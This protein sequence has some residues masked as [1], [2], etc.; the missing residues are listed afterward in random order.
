M[1]GVIVPQNT[2]PKVLA[3]DSA[4]L[5]L[6]GVR[7]YG[8]VKKT[9]LQTQSTPFLLWHRKHGPRCCA[10]CGLQV[11]RI[12]EKSPVLPNLYGS[13]TANGLDVWGTAMAAYL[14][15]NQF[16][17]NFENSFEKDKALHN[18]VFRNAEAKLQLWIH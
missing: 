16:S 3:P 4:R 6:Q 8:Q 14:H 13:A 18:F 17:E 5:L 11:H 1:S 12:R 10:R 9:R 7:W 2:Q 15:R